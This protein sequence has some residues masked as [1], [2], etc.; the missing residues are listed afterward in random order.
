MP[1]EIAH[2]TRF[3]TALKI[4]KSK[5]LWA[6]NFQFLNDRSEIHY[7]KKILFLAFLKASN[8]K[9]FTPA[10]D[11]AKKKIN[12]LYKALG[13]EIY[14]VSF[15]EYEAYENHKVTGTLSTPEDEGLLSMWRGYGADGGCAIIFD[16]NEL[17]N[18]WLKKNKDIQETKLFDQVQYNGLYHDNLKFN[19]K[20]K[21][22]PGNWD[23]HISNVN[24]KKLY[25]GK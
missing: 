4:L 11:S 8:I 24:E 14:I 6:T 16:H 3:E 18:Y 15:C 20:L 21:R 10:F 17:D 19:K 7:A 12:T 13:K 2:Y 22:L 1:K 5:E 25:N 23:D 9:E